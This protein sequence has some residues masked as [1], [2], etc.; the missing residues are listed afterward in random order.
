M[1]RKECEVLFVRAKSEILWGRSSL[2][3]L[4]FLALRKEDSK[5]KGSWEKREWR[6]RKANEIEWQV[7]DWIERKGK[8]VSHCW[9]IYSFLGDFRPWISKR[10]IC[11]WLEKLR[12]GQLGLKS[13]IGRKEIGRSVWEKS[14]FQKIRTADRILRGDIFRFLKSVVV[15]DFCAVNHSDNSQIL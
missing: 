11:F 10:R 7:Q 8:S 3:Q 2:N 5:V 9:E 12:E 6:Q 1:R 13:A 4:T 14:I 15:P